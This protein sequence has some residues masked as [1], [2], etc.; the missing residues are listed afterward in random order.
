VRVLVTGAA[1]FTGRALVHDL[2]ARGDVVYGLHRP[3]GPIL[4]ALETVTPLAQDLAAPLASGFPNEID[5]VVHLAQSRRFRDFPE[6]AD[7]VFE[8]NANATVRLLAWARKAGAKSFIYASSGAVYAPG[9]EPAREDQATS[10]GNFYA[11]SKRCGELVCEQFRDELTAHV[12]RFFFIY[13]PG[14]QDMFLPGVLGRV[15]DD[16]EVDLAGPDGIRVNPV[17]VDDAV[18]A[19]RGLLDRSESLTVNVAGPDVIS[20]R[21]AADLAGR[22]LGRRPRYAVGEAR[23]DLIASIDVLREA[24]LGPRVSFEEGLRRTVAAMAPAL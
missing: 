13:G 3:D 7:D 22:L 14:Q 11:A 24:G 15:A 10:L 6:G 19:I 8:V 12:L 16:R 21:E 4:P 5:A 9:S 2:A 1:G 17:Y 23:P 18:G 20:L